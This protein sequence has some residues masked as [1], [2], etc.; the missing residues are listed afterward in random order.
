MGVDKTWTPPSGPPWTLFWTPF[1]IPFWT[2]FWTPHFFVENKKKNR[3]KLGKVCM[4]HTTALFALSFLWF[5]IQLERRCSLDATHFQG[6][7]YYLRGG[8]FWPSATRIISWNLSFS[9]SIDDSRHFVFRHLRFSADQY[10]R[11]PLLACC[12]F[13][14]KGKNFMSKRPRKVLETKF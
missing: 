7:L 6:F 14:Q 12:C 1:W 8:S 13:P 5:S 4:L 9:S 10:Q 11:G 2:P 3:L